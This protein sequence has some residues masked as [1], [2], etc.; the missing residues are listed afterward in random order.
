MANVRYKEWT[1]ESNKIFKNE[2]HRSFSRYGWFKD[3]M[4]APA[5]VLEIGFN[6]GDA[7]SYLADLGF[8]CTGIELPRLAKLGSDP[9]I[10]YITQNMDSPNGEQLASLFN[11]EF[12]YVILGEVLQHLVFD[13]NCLYAIWHYL[14]PNGKILLSTENRKIVRH[15]LRYYD[16]SGLIKTLE[17]L[18]FKV[19]DFTLTEQPG[20]IWVCARKVI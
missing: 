8:E 9:R 10:E 2:G 4:K 18:Q 3:R 16:S 15:A 14:K 20:Y 6:S 17:V 11:E 12:D 1:Q 5:K 13:E 19:E 7:L